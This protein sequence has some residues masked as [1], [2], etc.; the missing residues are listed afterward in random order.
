MKP[1]WKSFLEDAG[2][3]WSEDGSV[4]HF[5]NANR[6]LQVSTTGDILC[7]LSHMGLISASGEEMRSFF[8]GQLTNDI[9]KVDARHAQLSAYCSPKGR[10]LA[11]FRVFQRESTVYLQLPRPNLEETLKRLR[12]F[13][14]MS[15][16]NL[17]DAT[18]AL[19]SFGFAG[20][21]AEARL[22]TLL[23][24]CPTENDLAQD[25]NGITVIRIPGPAPRF[26]IHGQLDD[27]KRLWN[28]INVNAAPAGAST[29]RLLDVLA[30]VP[31]VHFET[32]ES[33]VP[34][35]ANMERINGISFTKGCYT[36][37]EIVA[38]MQYL[39][40]LKRRM[41][42]AIVDAEAKPG[43]EVYIPTNASPTGKVSEAAPHP[44]GGFAIS[45]VMQISSYEKNDVHLGGQDGPVLTFLKLPYSLVD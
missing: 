8:Q 3:E 43:D 38:R 7:D 16:V 25:K 2:A 9:E 27:M 32:R 35:M 36:G 5:G 40:Q 42:S 19:V 18:D 30:V 41:Y 14:M 37:Q 6:E 45:V 1:E 24:S 21:N 34:Q 23:G 12:M 44:D 26:E 29:W 11:I 15:K 13:V 10:M 33:F 17:E 22:N 4:A 20:P 28:Q 39:G 31:V